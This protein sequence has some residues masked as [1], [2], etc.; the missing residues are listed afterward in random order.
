MGWGRGGGG[1]GPSPTDEEERERE[2]RREKRM[3][4][5]GKMCPM[6]Y[7]NATLTFNDNFNIV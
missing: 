2:N 1:L 5:R 4:E 6:C 3:E 7:V